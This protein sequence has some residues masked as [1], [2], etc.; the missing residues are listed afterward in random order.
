MVGAARGRAGDRGRGHD[1][2]CLAA[3][4]P[5]HRGA[6]DYGGAGG[7]AAVDGRKRDRARQAGM[8]DWVFLDVGNVLFNDDPQ[9][10]QGYRIVYEAIRDRLPAYSFA[11]M[12][13]EREDWAC[14]GADFILPKIAGLHFSS[15]EGKALFRSVRATLIEHY[16][17]YNLVNE[18]VSALLDQLTAHWRL[19]IIANQPPECRKSLKRRGLLDRFEVVAI[20][21]EVE[22]HKP[23]VRLFHWALEKA[24]CDASRSVM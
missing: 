4:Q 24:G 7:V 22:L 2:H 6:G 18:G 14:K 21:D 12:L 10:F 15:D 11:A 19:G 3:G 23:D 8:I 20:S 5:K 16:D 17:E 13:A 9:N 1:S